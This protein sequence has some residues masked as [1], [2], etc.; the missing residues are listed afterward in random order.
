MHAFESGAKSTE[1]KP[2]YDLV[3]I[4]AITY[5]AERLSFGAQ[6]H[7]DR[8]WQ[9]GIN[10]AAFIRDRKNHAVEH[11][12][13]YVT[14]TNLPPD[15]TGKV[16]TPKDHL[17]AAITNLAMLAYIEEHRNDTTSPTVDVRGAERHRVGT[18][19]R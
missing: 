9:K 5:I 18:G 8:N 1:E 10:D 3:P 14:G 4:E 13:A 16:D 12:L 17:K 2:R 15:K 19:P 7:G 6:R 11:L